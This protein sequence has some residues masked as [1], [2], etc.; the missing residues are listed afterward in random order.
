MRQDYHTRPNERRRPSRPWRSVRLS[1]R[2][3]PGLRAFPIC[4]RERPESHAG[5][6]WRAAFGLPLIYRDQSEIV[7]ARVRYEQGLSDWQRRDDLARSI[8]Q[9][10]EAFGN[11]RLAEQG[12]NDLKLQRLYGTLVGT[13]VSQAFP[14]TFK[15]IGKRRDRRRIGFLSANFHD[16]HPVQKLF[17][18]WLQYLDRDEF[19]SSSLSCRSQRRRTTTFERSQKS[20][21]T[22]LVPLAPLN[23]CRAY[24]GIR[25][26]RTDL[27]RCRQFPLFSSIGCDEARA[28]SMCDVGTSFDH[29]LQHHRLFL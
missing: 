9:T 2:F 3:R 11:D 13:A 17:S 26:G 21:K 7:T 29:R 24:P 8:P 28:R 1:R 27:P 14:R 4:C 23:T 18:G 19:E 6:A 15:Y 25:L 5:A 10:I 12:Q 20:A 22:C 16:G